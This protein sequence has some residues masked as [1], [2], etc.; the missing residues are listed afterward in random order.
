MVADPLDEFGVALVPR[1]DGTKR[2][3]GGDGNGK[4]GTWPVLDKSNHARE[5]GCSNGEDLLQDLNMSPTFLLF[6][7]LALSGLAY[8]LGV[9]RAFSVAGG[10]KEAKCLHSRPTYYGLLMALWCCIPA[11]IVFGFW[12]AFEST[13]ITQLVVADLP[14]EVK[15]LPPDRM[16]L[17]VNNVR[18]MVDGN[19]VATHDPAIRAAVEDAL[20]L[21]YEY[22]AL[23]VVAL[24]LLGLAA[25]LVWWRIKPAL[26]ARNQVEF[27]LKGLMIVCSTI[28]IFTTIGIVLSVLFESIRFFSMVPITEF[29]FGL[30][31][32]PQIAIREDQVGASGAF[33]AIPVF[34]GTL[35]ISAIAMSVA[36][37][38]GLMSAIYLSEYAGKHL[39][40][41]AKP[42][43]EILAGIPTVVY[44]FFAALIVAP[45]IREAGGFLGLNVASE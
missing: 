19:I 22:G 9:R 11:L 44:G 16:N 15:G 1:V 13:I 21:K 23:A 35:L 14:P 24:S 27:V 33:G 10:V 29:L 7:V 25:G 5:P 45:H 43:M 34:A 26:R 40:A 30:E 42:L 6:I 2:T 36:V 31:W 32:S 17:F 20:V 41:A 38:I 4:S 39:R 28:A 37:P 12:L 3:G 18:N 8:Y